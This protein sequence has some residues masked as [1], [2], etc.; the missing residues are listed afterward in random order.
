ML[1]LGVMSGEVKTK[2][3]FGLTGVDGRDGEG[4]VELL[5]GHE[6]ERAGRDTT[7]PDCVIEV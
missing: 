7:C 4:V 3:D 5:C 1:S 2:T 6:G